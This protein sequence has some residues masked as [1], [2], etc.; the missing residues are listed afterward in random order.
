MPNI[1]DTFVLRVPAEQ[2]RITALLY[3]HSEYE[4]KTYE[5]GSS[6]GV[7]FTYTLG[8]PSTH[9]TPFQIGWEK[10]STG[11]DSSSAGTPSGVFSPVRPVRTTQNGIRMSANERQVGTLVGKLPLDKGII[12]TGR[13]TMV[14]PDE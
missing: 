8:H 3:V 9:Q 4:D 7:T 2:E 5:A 1:S 11:N 10:K 13:I 6:Y 14:Q 12:Y